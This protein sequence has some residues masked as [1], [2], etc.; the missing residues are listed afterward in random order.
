[1]LS[2]LY[3]MFVIAV[4]VVMFPIALVVRI[5]TAPFDRRRAVLH[6]FTCVW[7]GLYTWCNPLWRVE[8]V[9][10]ERANLRLLPDATTPVYVIVANHLSLV[11][12][13]VLHRLF[14]HFKW[15][16]KIENFRLPFI[17]WNM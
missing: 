7:A 1:M 11:D 17:G 9:G 8:V 16:S 3:W 2:A 10:R 13:F 12:I 6:A 15:V 14:T 5:V 4:A